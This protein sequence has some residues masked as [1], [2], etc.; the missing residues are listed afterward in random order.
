MMGWPHRLLRF[1][2]DA[3]GS[4]WAGIALGAVFAVPVWCAFGVI[5]WARMVVRVASEGE[6]SAN[7][8]ANQ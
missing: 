8:Q 4:T 6:C 7:W 2:S 3:A 1:A 5:L